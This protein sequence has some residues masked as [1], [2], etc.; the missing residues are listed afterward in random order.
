MALEELGIISRKLFT[1]SHITLSFCSQ[2]AFG[3]NAH[4]SQ[5]LA[6]LAK[7]PGL[8]GNSLIS[9]AE[10]RTWKS[11][12]ARSLPDCKN[13]ADSGEKKDYSIFIFCPKPCDVIIRTF[14]PIAKENRSV[15]PGGERGISLRMMT[16]QNTLISAP[17]N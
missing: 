17:S 2:K 10:C 14:I 8:R 12:G 9:T 1:P 11:S 13:P 4:D 6:T 16:L 5:A 7:I 3:F 15:N